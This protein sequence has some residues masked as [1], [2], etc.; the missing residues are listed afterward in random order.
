[1]IF[2]TDITIP[3][4]TSSTSPT[5]VDLGIARGVI[6]KFMVRPR[7]GHAGL[8]HCVIR[9]HGHLIAPTTDNMDIHGDADPIDWEDHIEINQPPF[10]LVIQ[11]WNEDDTFP[12]TF[13]I[14]VVVLPKSALLVNSI[15]ELL[16]GV[17]GLLMPK[18]VNPG[19][20]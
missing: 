19:G 2:S 16:R 3:K 20:P 7:P 5:V 6:T 4:S 15:G 18:R 12:H 13:T 14:Y 9:Y 10:K 17:F 8:A 1:M 11:G